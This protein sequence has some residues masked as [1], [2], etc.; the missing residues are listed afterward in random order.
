MGLGGIGGFG[1]AEGGGVPGPYG[2]PRI[3]DNKKSPNNTDTSMEGIDNQSDADDPGTPTKPHWE[4]TPSGPAVPTPDSQG[5][6]PTLIIGATIKLMWIQND[7]KTFTVGTWGIA[8]KGRDF[9]GSAWDK[10]GFAYEVSPTPSET[11]HVEWLDIDTAS[12]G[13]ASK[14]K[15]M[16]AAYYAYFIYAKGIRKED[17]RIMYSDHTE[18][19]Q[20]NPTKF[21]AYCDEIGPATIPL[22]P[23]VCLNPNTDITTTHQGLTKKVSI[24]LKSS[25]LR[26]VTGLVY[27]G[28]Y[29]DEGNYV[30][31]S[32]Q[33]GLTIG[34]VTVQPSGSSG[35]IDGFDVSNYVRIVA[36]SRWCNGGKTF[37]SA[38]SAVYTAPF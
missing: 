34:S 5:G 2:K 22:E 15:L 14:G 18:Q 27:M 35:L 32:T 9:G 26:P 19:Y 17:G 1:I 11:G 23:T 30:H 33:K 12:P 10:W 36:Y 25:S 6:G 8:R 38:K 31:K 28:E 4:A 13:H 24:R 21:N 16:D 3:L 7:A 37:Y 20:S 29:D